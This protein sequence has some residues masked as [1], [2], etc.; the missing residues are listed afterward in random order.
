[1][2]SCEFCDISKNTFFTEHI[3]TTA[4]KYSNFEKNFPKNENIL[5]KTAVPFFSWR[6]K[7]WKRN[8]S[9]QNR[10]VKK[11]ILRQ[12]EWIIQI[13]LT[14]K[15][16][17][18]PE[19]TFFLS[20]RISYKE[21]I[22]CTNYTNVH[23]HT[24]CNC[25]SFIRGAFSLWVTLKCIHVFFILRNTFFKAGWKFLSIPSISFLKVLS[26]LKAR[27]LKYKRR[28]MDTREVIY[29]RLVMHA[30]KKVFVK[31]IR[32]FC[33]KKLRSTEEIN[34]F[35]W[36]NIKRKWILQR[37]LFLQTFLA[38]FC[39]HQHLFNIKYFCMKRRLLSIFWTT[40]A[41]DFTNLISESSYQKQPFRGVLKR[42]S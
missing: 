24:F 37:K 6:Y 17:V 26:F 32:F 36:D 3:W 12:I 20:L 28:V 41:T 7:D 22:C 34:Q 39:W 25:W 10:P 30:R 2:F 42:C 23:I 1:M 27:F 8:I 40:N 11:P 38:E 16:E 21:M 35:L 5:L 29:V 15:N 9:I 4:S 13:G 33:F 19:T 31:L 18:L 14:I